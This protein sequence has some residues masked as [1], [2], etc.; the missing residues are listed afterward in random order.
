MDD[1]ATLRRE[2]AAKNA[3]ETAKVRQKLERKLA[4]REKELDKMVRGVATC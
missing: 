2:I 4:A 3:A 1:P